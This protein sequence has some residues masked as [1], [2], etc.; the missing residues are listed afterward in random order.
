MKQS[1]LFL[2][3]FR[4]LDMNQNNARRQ[5]QQRFPKQQ[6]TQP[7][8][9][10]IKLVKS[11]SSATLSSDADM[12]T[13][14]VQP[15]QVTA[16]V[17][18]STSIRP[19]SQNIFKI[20]DKLQLSETKHIR[21]KYQPAQA[22]V[23]PAE[24]A[25]TERWGVTLKRSN[26]LPNLHLQVDIQES[27]DDIDKPSVES[28]ASVASNP[29]KLA[30]KPGSNVPRTM[31]KSKVKEQPIHTPVP[32]NKT[33][34]TVQQASRTIFDIVK[35][36]DLKAKSS[37]N[38]NKLEAYQDT[39]SLKI[40]TQAQSSASPNDAVSQGAT[41]SIT[42]ARTSTTLK[43][44]E[45]SKIISPTVPANTPSSVSA[46]LSP[47]P[48]ST[49][50]PPSSFIDK[51]SDSGTSIAEPD[52]IISSQPRLPLERA[53]IDAKSRERASHAF[54]RISIDVSFI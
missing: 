27:H 37:I 24:P 30:D 22:E 12:S 50:I 9:N 44:T 51:R 17:S 41:H 8:T 47:A 6:S 45:H 3:L 28:I 29:F 4:D 10:P 33:L 46:I 31:H 34:M 48:L 36:F 32:V 38:I 49:E 54:R 53:S 52:L 13:A 11:V 19:V 16:A 21:V 23:R 15:D 1:P 5:E 7:Q 43:N 26:T 39:D 18:D 14:V 42:Q 25:A 40:I 35:N 2:K 20:N